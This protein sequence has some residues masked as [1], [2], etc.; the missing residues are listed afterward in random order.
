M[1]QRR[2]LQT[3]AVLLATQIVAACGVMGIAPPG[4]RHLFFPVENKSSVP[5][6]LFVAEYDSPMGRTVGTA[7]PTTVPPGLTQDV[8][9]TVPSGESWAIFVNP[10]PDSTGLIGARDVPPSM[11]GALPFRI[12][13]GE[14]G[15]PTVTV[16]GDPGSLG[17]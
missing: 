5:A 14:N 17:G 1:N 3:F 8:I 4:S 6:S 16:S 15:D 9:F 13:V 10:G 11:S 7:V 2:L 12:S